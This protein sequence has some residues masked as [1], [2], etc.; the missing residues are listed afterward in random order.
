MGE[1]AVL[2]NIQKQKVFQLQGEGLAPLTP[3]PGALPLDPAA[4]LRATAYAVPVA[5]LTFKVI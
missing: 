3:R 1:F 4:P 5:V 2:L